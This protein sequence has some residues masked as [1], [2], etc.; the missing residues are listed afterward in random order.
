MRPLETR[1]QEILTGFRF[2][3]PYWLIDFANPSIV[4]H[5]VGGYQVYDAIKFLEDN[6]GGDETLSFVYGV[7]GKDTTDDF[8]EDVGHSSS[9]RAMWMSTTPERSNHR[10][11][12]NL[13]LPSSHNTIKTPDFRPW[14]KIYE[15]NYHEICK[16]KH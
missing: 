7:V 8:K 5:L 12:I 4:A 9:V 15:H 13:L 3:M 10:L 2:L 6:T 16:I 14:G 1:H 11:S